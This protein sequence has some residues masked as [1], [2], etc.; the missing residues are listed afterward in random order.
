MQVEGLELGA[1]VQGREGGGPV[2]GL[3]FDRGDDEVGRGVRDESD[4]GGVEG[5]GVEELGGDWGR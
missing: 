3:L 5:P 1:G 4:G 2:D